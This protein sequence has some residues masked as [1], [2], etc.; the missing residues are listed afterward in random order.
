MYGII[1][2]VI[3]IAFYPGHQALKTLNELIVVPNK[4]LL[5]IVEPRCMVGYVKTTD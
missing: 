1:G 4:S 5:A 2:S 3:I